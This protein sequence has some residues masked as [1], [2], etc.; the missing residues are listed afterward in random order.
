MCGCCDDGKTAET[1]REVW[2]QEHY[3]LDPHT[4]VAWTV[5]EQHRSKL[6][7]PTVVLSTA[8]PYKF[9][10]A[11]LAALGE[12]VPEN[13]FDAMEKLHELTETDIPA[14]LAELAGLPV[15][16]RDCIAKEEMLTYV[17]SRMEG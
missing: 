1:I 7:G 3:L 16:H 15:R 10:P 12:N 11:V 13:A 5:A 4:A 8:S 2:E 9:A 14:P 6:R 17:R